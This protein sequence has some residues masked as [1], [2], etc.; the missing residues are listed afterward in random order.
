[1]KRGLLLSC[2]ATIILLGSFTS[3][4]DW[5]K[6]TST[7]GK[8]SINFPGK[9]TESVQ[10][11]TGENGSV[12]TIHMATYEVSETQVYLSSFIDMH[13]YYPE[14]KSLKQI[15]ED[16]RDGATAS[17]SATNIVT[18]ATNLGKNA[19]IEFTFNTSELTG[20]DRIYMI[21]K[22]QYSVIVLN[23]KDKGLGD[24]DK[25]ITSFTHL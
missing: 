22:F 18:T 4:K 23:S 21:D 10:S 11:D 1:M 16:S 13:S 17:M 8:Y 3:S 9:P 20:K 12:L 7:E 19:Y 15:L 6:Y 24:A 25:F 5:Y 14:S 2:I